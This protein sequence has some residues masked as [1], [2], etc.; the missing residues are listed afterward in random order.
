MGAEPTSGTALGQSETL[1]SFSEVAARRGLRMTRPRR[2]VLAAIVA[3]GRPFSATELTEAMARRDG[4][5]G[6]A[7]VYRTLDLLLR[8]GWVRRLHGAGKERYT[9]CLDMAHHHHVTCRGCGRTEEFSLGNVAGFE[10][11]VDA[12]V[13]SLGFVAEGHVLEVHGLCPRCGAG[14]GDSEGDR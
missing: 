5:V 12:A 3:L 9:L 13:R 6:R 14:R 4:S 2:A 8:A 10:D 11:A 7:S 1:R